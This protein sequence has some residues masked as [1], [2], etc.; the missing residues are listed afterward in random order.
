MLIV[1]ADDIGASLTATNAAILAFREG[2]I[3]SGSAMVWMRDSARAAHLARDRGL[4][5]GLHLNLTLP[6]DTANVPAPVRR[7]QLLLTEAFDSASWRGDNADR[8]SRQLLRDAVSDQLD[9]F[10][11]QFGDPTH[12]DGHHHVHVHEAVFEVLP[13]GLAIRPILR[14]PT[15]A[16]ARASQRDRRM[17][18]R[19]RMPSLTLAFEHLHPALGGV[20]FDVLQ[21]AQRESVEVMTHPQ[22]DGQFEALVSAQ[23]RAALA[24]LPVGSF[25]ALR[26][27]S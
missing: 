21:R 11:E 1:N 6:F 27:S 15:Q 20:G 4:P 23:W 18:K 17:R 16:D 10:I 5:A 7:R 22:Q 13:P 3:S 25:A 24:R 14:E 19:F 8:P 2:V 12:L 9:Q 26:P